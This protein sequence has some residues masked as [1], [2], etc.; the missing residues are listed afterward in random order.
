VPEQAAKNYL[1]LSSESNMNDSDRKKN[2]ETNEKST[3]TN[4]RGKRAE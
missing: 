1:V 4:I 3:E 2:Y